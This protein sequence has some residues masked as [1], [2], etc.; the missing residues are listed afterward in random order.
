M[1]FSKELEVFVYSLSLMPCLRRF[2]RVIKCDDCNGWNNEVELWNE[3][4]SSLRVWVFSPIN[5][6]HVPLPFEVH[7]VSGFHRHYTISRYYMVYIDILFIRTKSLESLDAFYIASKLYIYI[8]IY[9]LLYVF[10]LIYLSNFA[11]KLLNAKKRQRNASKQT[12]IIMCLLC[13]VF[14]YTLF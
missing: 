7:T 5:V 4:K 8:Y 2:N 11:A 6:I 12:I 13:L 10:L 9:I 3:A 14:G 1:Y